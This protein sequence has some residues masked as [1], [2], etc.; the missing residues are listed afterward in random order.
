MEEGTRSKVVFVKSD[1]VLLH[2]IVDPA[3][4]PQ[5]MGGT[6][7]GNHPYLTSSA[8]TSRET[9]TLKMDTPSDSCLL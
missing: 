2:R 6:R 7:P 4:L 3:I 9:Q 1:Y 8:G 5:E